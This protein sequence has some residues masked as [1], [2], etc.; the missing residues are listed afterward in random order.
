MVVAPDHAYQALADLLRGAQHEILIGGYT[1]ESVWLTGVLTERLAAGVSVSM[2]LE[3][4]PAGGLA[5]AELWNCDQIVRAGGQVRFMHSDEAEHIA[6]RYRYYHAKYV[7]VDGRWAAIGSENFGNHA[8]PVDDKADGTAGD[9]GVFLI[10][11]QPQVVDRCAGS[12]PA[13]QRSEP[14]S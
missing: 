11:D 6:A 1:F 4:G 14:P 8:L 9:R 2:L 3:G 10:T 5:E 12:V 7:V 13:G